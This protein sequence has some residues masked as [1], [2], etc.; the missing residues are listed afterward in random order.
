[1]HRVGRCRWWVGLLVP[2]RAL[3]SLSQEVLE[4]VE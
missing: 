4:W 2:P 1:L 3:R